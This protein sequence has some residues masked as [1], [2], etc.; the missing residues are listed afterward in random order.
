MVV[1]QERTVREN[2]VS[3]T[4]ADWAAG[5]ANVITVIRSGA[6]AAGQIGPH[7]LTPSDRYV[8]QVY[9]TTVS[10]SEQVEVETT[11]DPTT[12]NITLTKSPVPP[13]FPG[14]LV[15]VGR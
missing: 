2:D 13:D 12:G 7:G 15:I 6:P 3:F 9:D 1:E 4:A 10:P 5:V 11:I 8:I 14:Y